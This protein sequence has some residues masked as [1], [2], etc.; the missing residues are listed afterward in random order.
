MQALIL[1]AV[2]LL[3]AGLVFAQPAPD[4]ETRRIREIRLF[5]SDV[6]SEE[7]A[8][9]SS[10]AK[11]VNK[12]HITTR[13]S[14]IRNQILF[15]EGDVLDKDLVEQS[16]RKL[17]R[18]QFLNKAQIEVVPVDDQRVDIEIRTQDAWSLVPGLNF[19][20][21]GD[22]YTINVLMQELNL[23]GTGKKAFV[24]G[25]YES[26]LDDWTFR[27][28][29][30]DPQVFNSR[31]VGSVTYTTGPLTESFFVA[32]S[33]PLYS[34]DAKWSFGGHVYTAD[35]IIRRFE[36]G[37]ESSRFEKDQITVHGFVKRS[38]GERFKK[39]N[40]KFSVGYLKKDFSPLGSATT[41][42][43]PEDQANVTP[44]IKISKTS[45]GSFKEVTYINKMG[46]TED[47]WLGH[48]YG[49]NVGYG[50][51]VENGFEL[52]DVGG[53][54][55]SSV[56]FKYKQQLKTVLNLSS[57]VVR[58]TIAIASLRYYK[59]FSW[60][61]VATRFKLNYG[62]E[63]DSTRQFTLGADSGL[64]GYPARQFTG[65]RLMLF[66]LEDRQF[67]GDYSLG[68]KFALG[69][70]VFVDAGNVWKE[71]EDVDLNDLNWS[72]GAGLRLGWSNLPKQ[73][74]LRIDFGWG[75]GG[76]DDFAVTVGME[77]HF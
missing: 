21:G 33:R 63:L 71:T 44:A 58:N 34:I 53:F 5:I 22:L 28:G 73:P 48:S 31:W 60:H 67:W 11:Y 10:L 46:L 30:R 16:E 49:A 12:Y 50:I 54:Y 29:Y 23:F 4:G 32:A 65:E 70:V 14:V 77:Q 25:I 59:K 76:S 45:T 1:L 56:S 24:E 72:A 36:N 62:W 51:P 26:D 19:G 13:E 43:I 64:R 6:Y 15:K 68:P 75:L 38:F 47:I 7:E 35:Q 55:S 69:T 18:F 37:D 20:G 17:R 57:E 27:L 39:T 3:S 52:W 2:L 9:E 41:E 8:Q 40:V 74:I 61:T 42:P 66:N